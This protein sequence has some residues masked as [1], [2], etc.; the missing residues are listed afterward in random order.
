MIFLMIGS[1]DRR[2]MD[3]WKAVNLADVGQ[4]NRDFSLSYCCQLAEHKQNDGLHSA[5][6]NP[7]SE[8]ILSPQNE[9]FNTFDFI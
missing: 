3:Y 7:H 4:L 5:P 6:T 8:L 2:L 1:V 9:H